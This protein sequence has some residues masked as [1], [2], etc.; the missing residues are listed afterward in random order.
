MAVGKTTQ[1]LGHHGKQLVG[2]GRG[3]DQISIHFVP[4]FPINSIFLKIGIA[5]VQI[6]PKN[7]KISFRLTS[8]VGFY[9]QFFARRKHQ[10]NE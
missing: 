3:C 2:G 9:Q 7:L 4:A 10:Q 8:R 5:I 6:V 1:H